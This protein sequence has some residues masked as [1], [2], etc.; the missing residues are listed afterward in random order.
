MTAAHLAQGEGWRRAGHGRLLACTNPLSIALRELAQ[1]LGWGPGLS[2]VSSWGGVRMWAWGR[3][4]VEL[5]LDAEGEGW[6]RAWAAGRLQEPRSLRLWVVAPPHHRSPRPAAA[7]GLPATLDR[8]TGGHS[9]TPS[10]PAQ[11]PAHGRGWRKAKPVWQIHQERDEA[12]AKA[13]GERRLVDLAHEAAIAEHER[14][15]ELRRVPALPLVQDGGRLRGR[16]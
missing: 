11:R 4:E 12:A 8:P 10:A 16:T 3:P 2:V 5:A 13:A 15:E 7:E 9:A 1:E 14:W 6:M